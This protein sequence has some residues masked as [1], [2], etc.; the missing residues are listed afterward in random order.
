MGQRNGLSNIDI[1]KINKMYDCE[2]KLKAAAA[3][4]DLFLALRIFLAG[5]LLVL[6]WYIKISPWIDIIFS[7]Q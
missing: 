1:L 6:V 7:E 2:Q 3:K 4:N 5:S